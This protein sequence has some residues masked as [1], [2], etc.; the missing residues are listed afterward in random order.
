MGDISQLLSGISVRVTD[1]INAYMQDAFIVDKVMMV[2]HGMASAKVAGSD[3][4]PDLIYQKFWH[5]VG[6]NVCDF[7]LH[8]LNDGG[9]LFE[10]D[11]TNIVFIPKQHDPKNMTHLEL[12]HSF[13]RL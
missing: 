12:L 11:D 6:T 5:I 3:G 13:R 4:L 10:I 9:F 2:V 1:D 7:C 8:I